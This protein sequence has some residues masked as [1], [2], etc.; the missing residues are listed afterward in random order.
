LVDDDADGKERE[1]EGTAALL[2]A[3]PPCD[4]AS[5]PG[6]AR[7]DAATLVAWAS[8]TPG[9]GVHIRFESSESESGW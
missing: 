7:T 9:G 6:V 5:P 1:E 3:E 2:T 8:A 4:S